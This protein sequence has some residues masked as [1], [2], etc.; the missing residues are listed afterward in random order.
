MGPP[1]AGA[2]VG[3]LFAVLA[4]QIAASFLSRIAPTL[5]PKL[6][7]RVGWP[8]ESVGYMAALITAGSAVLQRFAPNGHRN[9]LFSIKQSGV[10]LGGV[11]VSF[12]AGPALSGLIVPAGGG[13]GMAFG[14]TA[15]VTLAALIPL[16]RC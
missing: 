16:S 2:W 8:V 10:P 9:L 15:L 3:P 7:M 1:D 4:V 12:I 13:F 5:A 11:L 6:A 14:A